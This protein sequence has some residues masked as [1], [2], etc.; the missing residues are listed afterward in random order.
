MQHTQSQSRSRQIHA[1]AHPRRRTTPAEHVH[2]KTTEEESPV[3]LRVSF[4]VHPA[5]AP[6]L[7]SAVEEI[8]NT[9]ATRMESKHDYEV[10]DT[11]VRA[12]I[13]LGDL[14]AAVRRAFTEYGVTS[15]EAE[16][17]DPMYKVGRGK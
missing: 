16:L 2:G 8:S 3:M 12:T 15:T 11:L 5:H 1:P 13:A 4:A 6:A 14:R 7:W 9:V 17:G 10:E